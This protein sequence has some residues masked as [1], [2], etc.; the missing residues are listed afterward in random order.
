MNMLQ[1]S[2]KF[3]AAIL[4]VTLSGCLTIEENYT[5][6]K[7]GSGTMEYVVDMTEMGEMMKTIGEMGA[8]EGS[9]TPDE[10]G[11][12]DMKEELAALKKIPGIKRV[13]LD[14]KKKWIQRVNFKFKDITALNAALN[15][16]MP[17]STGQPY[18]FFRWEGNTLVRTNNRHAYE[19]GAGMAKE[20]AKTER[21]EEEEG[22]DMGAFLE[23]MKYKYSF[24]FANDVSS[25]QQVEAMK[26]ETPD[27]RLL[28]LETD[29]SVISKD[30]QALDLRIVLD[31]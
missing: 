7:D 31:R 30:P 4:L 14:E 9:A 13:K 16:L 5:F 8:E 25:T 1:R 11:T 6:K 2:L 27:S 22:M 26:K 15:I 19:V 21:A 29:W 23:A 12:L 24:K 20:D 28:K 17:D 10:L 3:A 18:E